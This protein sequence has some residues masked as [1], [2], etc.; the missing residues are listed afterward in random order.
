[1]ESVTDGSKYVDETWN[2][3]ERKAG[4]IVL[5]EKS[6]PVPFRWQTFSHRQTSDRNGISALIDH[7]LT[8]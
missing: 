7:S 5:G 6:V 4:L 3:T 1:M 2:D 8:A